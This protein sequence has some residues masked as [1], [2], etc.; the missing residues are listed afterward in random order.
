VCLDLQPQNERREP[1]K[2]AATCLFKPPVEKGPAKLDKLFAINLALILALGLGVSGWLIRYTSL[3]E[4]F[5]GL[6]ALGGLLS[7]LAFVGKL[8]PE[9]QLAALQLKLYEWIFKRGVTSFVL[10][11]LLGVGCLVAFCFGTIQLQLME[12]PAQRDAWIYPLGGSPAV[13]LRLVKDETLRKLCWTGFPGRQFVVKVSGYPAKIL[14]VGPWERLPLRI[15][16]QLNRPVVLLLPKS[17]LIDFV[18]VGRMRMAVAIERSGQVRES[19]VDYDGESVWVGCDE[20]VDIP[21][22]DEGE[23]ALGGVAEEDRAPV[24][25]KWSRP[26]SATTNPSSQELQAGDLISLKLIGK[27]E[28]PKVFKVFKEFPVEKRRSWDHPQVR[29]L[30]AQ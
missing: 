25:R 2:E 29:I 11:G 20:N 4:Q 12:D 21:I 22:T 10:L 24:R 30:D 26:R 16:T 15:P 27:A 14:R 5:V 23:R 9:E 1:Q 7:W 19:V 28:L 13:P 18:G 3:F 17:G 8:L 6:L